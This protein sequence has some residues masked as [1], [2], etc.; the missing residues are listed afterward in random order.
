MGCC[1]SSMFV[2]TPTILQMLPRHRRL[3]VACAVLLAACGGGDPP[4]SP[5][6]TPT[7]PPPAATSGAVRVSAT[8]RGESLPAGRYLVRVGTL[9]AALDANGSVRFDSVPTGVQSVSLDSVP[10]NCIVASGNTRSITVAAN[11][12]GELAF[13]IDC[14]RDDTGAL[15]APVVCSSL[16]AAAAQ[17]R[18]LQEVSLGQLPAQLEGQLVARTSTGP[19]TATSLGIVGRDTA[20]NATFVVP[21]HPGA[22]MSGG[23]VTVRVGDDTRTC[24]PFAFRIDPLP[25]APGEYANIVQRLQL[26]VEQQAALLGTSVMELQQARLD[27]LPSVLLPLALSQSA[28]DHPRNPNSLRALQDRLEPGALTLLDALLA[29]AELRASLAPASPMVSMTSPWNVARFPVAPGARGLANTGVNSV[30]PRMCTSNI[31]DAGIL[32]DCMELARAAAF[33]LISPTT[34]LQNDMGSA[35][36]LAGLV[37][38]PAVKVAATAIGLLQFARQTLREGTAGLFPSTLT[39]LTINATP[40]RFKEDEDGPGTWSARVT[41]QS[42]G[43]KLDALALNTLFQLTG[44]RQGWLDRYADLELKSDMLGVILN[45]VV[46]EAINTSATGSGFLEFVPQSFGPA[47]VSSFEFSE[48][49]IATGTSIV[50]GIHSNY[51]PRDVGVSQLRVRTRTGRFGGQQASANTAITVGQLRLRFTAGANTITEERVRKNT[52]YLFTITVDESSHPEEVDVDPI[53]EGAGTIVVTKGCGTIQVR[54]TTPDKLDAL[55]FLIT[56]RH[57]AKSGARAFNTDPR[58]ASLAIL[59]IELR[60]S[61]SSGC[62]KFGETL[63]F[64]ATLADVV[65]NDVTWSASIGSINSGGV[66]TA[67]SSAAAGAE[68]VIRAQITTEDGD[69]DE[70]VR[71]QVGT[72]TCSGTLALGSPIN[73]TWD[74]LAAWSLNSTGF[75]VGM[76][77]AGSTAMQQMFP[78]RRMNFGATF[79]G[80]P[81]TG[82]FTLRT[83]NVF[84]ALTA[85]NTVVGTIDPTDPRFLGEGQVSI[86]AFTPGEFMQG[87][88]IG[89]IRVVTAEFDAGIIVPMRFTFRALFG[90]RLQPNTPFF[91][92]YLESQGDDNDPDEDL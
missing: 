55:P 34:K 53:P 46:Q 16:Q 85:T 17:G 1:V 73:R 62:V 86:T 10:L 48:A 27:T 89:S 63:A 64:T 41:A 15:L 22:G 32:D 38:N 90:S 25:P 76:I 83:A 61:P 19:G 33:K 56:A 45:I 39:S 69:F 37:P 18:P 35:L 74:G 84:G 54:Y 14:T 65:R 2:S 20:G 52:T 7:N 77:P 43:W 67:P 6:P 21:L 11:A 29:L 88:L 47:D 66:F 58:V 8:T 82:G 5:T 26:I 79:S 36:G 31:T 92:C 40:T 60:I 49:D 91:Q 71:V 57:T 4:S 42:A 87:T 12:A 13:D 59:P 75:G 50:T 44:A 24:A 80:A 28:I 78:E 51:D 70:S 81:G 3:L 23:D 30:S 68:A 72:C 9:S